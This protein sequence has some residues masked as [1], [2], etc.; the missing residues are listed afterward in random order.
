LGHFREATT[1]VPDEPPPNAGLTTGGKTEQAI[2]VKLI[3]KSKQ[4]RSD[5]AILNINIL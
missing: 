2:S 3:S 1:V 5:K 4:N